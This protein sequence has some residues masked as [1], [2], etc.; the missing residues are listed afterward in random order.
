MTFGYIMSVDQMSYCSSSV[1][2]CGAKLFMTIIK[3]TL[4]LCMFTIFGRHK[5]EFA[6]VQK[7]L[8]KRN[9]QERLKSNLYKCY[10]HHHALVYRKDV[11]VCHLTTFMQLMYPTLTDPCPICCPISLLLQFMR[12]LS[13]CFCLELSFY[14]LFT[15]F[16]Q[17][18]KL[19]SP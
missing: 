1:L 11:S 15:R 18:G 17:R 16:E 7:L 8:Q 19:H 9:K 14:H 12:T 10:Y 6:I 13:V 3:N 2:R 5:R 4:R